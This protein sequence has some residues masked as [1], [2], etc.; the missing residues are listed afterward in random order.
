M[1][2]S[3]LIIMDLHMLESENFVCVAENGVDHLL[4]TSESASDIKLEE[5]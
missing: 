1:T 4:K 5:T 2:T 3:E